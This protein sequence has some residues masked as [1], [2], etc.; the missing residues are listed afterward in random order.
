M[1]VV[2]KSTGT[3]IVSTTKHDLPDPPGGV[4]I[5]PVFSSTIKDNQ[6]GKAVYEDFLP[7]ALKAGTFVPAPEALV[8][9]KGVE[10]VQGAVDLLQKGVSATKVVLSL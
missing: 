6:V 5:K 9:G 7:G 1:D 3:K 8:A 10:S 2:R 4:T